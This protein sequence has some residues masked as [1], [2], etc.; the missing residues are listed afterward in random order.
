M[1]ISYRKLREKKLES[2]LGWREIQKRIH[3][4][5]EVIAR[6]NKDK[7]ISLNSLEKFC[8]FFGC[9]FGDLIEY[10]KT[11]DTKRTQP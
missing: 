3:L 10:K 8:E 11:K 1:P 7:Y 4:T 5:N 2:N 6:L 9:D